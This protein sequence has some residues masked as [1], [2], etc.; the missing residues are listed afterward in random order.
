MPTQQGYSMTNLFKKAHEMT[1]EIKK[2]FP[3]VDYKFQFVLCVKYLSK[4]GEHM[5]LTGSD[6]QIKWAND[7][8]EKLLNSF[9]G[10]TMSSV[11]APIIRTG[12]TPKKTE[13]MA[14]MK[15][16]ITNDIE[17][18]NSIIINMLK[19]IVNSETSAVVFIENK[20]IGLFLNNYFNN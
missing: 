2:E 10:Q 14:T 9:D 17:A 3:D 12:N 13:F 6:K 8:R 4:E 20:S 5:D 15:S 7:I 1:K 19:D 16:K 18:N 11:I